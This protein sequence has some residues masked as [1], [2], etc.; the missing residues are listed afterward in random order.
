MINRVREVKD[1]RV[2]CDPI[3]ALVTETW[4][5]VQEDSQ[6]EG[7][8]LI[9]P[10][11]KN[12]IPGERNGG[13][14]AGRSLNKPRIHPAGSAQSIQCIFRATDVKKIADASV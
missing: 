4:H 5:V 12:A 8:L 14:L 3:I 9:A 1:S 11:A 2:P 10:L 7:S 13:G 6:S